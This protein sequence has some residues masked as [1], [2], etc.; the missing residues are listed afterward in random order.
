MIAKYQLNQERRLSATVVVRDA[1]L[2]ARMTVVRHYSVLTKERA[3]SLCV[4][5][6]CTDPS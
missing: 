6:S 2:H 3:P 5:V 1:E 4:N